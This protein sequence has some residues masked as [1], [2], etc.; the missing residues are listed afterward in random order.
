MARNNNAWQ[1]NAIRNLGVSGMTA[2]YTVTYEA[3]EF[4][5][6]YNAA[7]A[8]NI[9]VL[10]LGTN[11]IGISGQT[12]VQTISSIK[13]LGIYLKS[14]GFKVVC[15]TILPR[16]G[17]TGTENTYVGNVNAYIQGTNGSVIA[18]G[19]ADVIVDLTLNSHLYPLA[20]YQAGYTIDGGTHPND[21]GYSI[22]APLIWS[23]VSS[24]F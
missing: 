22:I 23:A 4:P 17:F 11:D 8:K 2:T 20:N 10:W 14:L 5:P 9:A 1:T 16:A 19:A 18:D 21:A 7:Y 15:V 24:L 6:E 12:D 13:T 3:D